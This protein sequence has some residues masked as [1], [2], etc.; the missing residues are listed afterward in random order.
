MEVQGWSPL[1]KTL[2]CNRFMWQSCEG[3]GLIRPLPTTQMIAV[4][5]ANIPAAVMSGK[6]LKAAAEVCCRPSRARGGGE[7]SAAV[8][9]CLLI[10]TNAESFPDAVKLQLLRLHSRTS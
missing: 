1:E 9:V 6:A 8:F 3:Q 5:F 10:K 2:Q 4:R 7:T